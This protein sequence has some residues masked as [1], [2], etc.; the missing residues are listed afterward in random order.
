MKITPN[1]GRLLH[2][3]VSETEFNFLKYKSEEIDM[4]ISAI[5]R[6][7][8][9]CFYI[10]ELKRNDNYKDYIEHQL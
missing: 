6:G 3:R 2:L 9:D 8:I 5:I 10:E 1:K 4:S 7:F